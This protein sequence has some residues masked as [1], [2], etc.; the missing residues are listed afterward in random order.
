M[1]VPATAGGGDAGRLAG[2]VAA[3]DEHKRLVFDAEI[4]ADDDDA[5]DLHR[6]SR[7]VRK[8]RPSE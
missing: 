2:A 8:H 6:P 4:K 7:N 1:T 5:I 3:G